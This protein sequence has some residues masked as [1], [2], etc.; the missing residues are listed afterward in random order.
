MSLVQYIYTSVLATELTAQ[1]AFDTSSLS[2]KVCEQFGITG[3]VFAN[4]RQALAITEG[5]EMH[6]AR[7]FQAVQQDPMA[8]T[9]ILHVQ[10]PI[11]AREFQDYSVWLN[12]GRNL[13]FTQ[14]VRELTAETLPLAWPE[15]LSP[16]VRI[17]ANAYLDA[18]ML[19][20]C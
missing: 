7:Y 16:R 3:R 9:Q 1:N 13:A 14:N 6:V 17:M 15:N 5:P 10:R 19:E 12:V 18:D 11:H 20:A 2:V 8:G 4:R